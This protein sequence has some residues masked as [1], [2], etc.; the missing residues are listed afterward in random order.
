ML[1]GYLSRETSKLWVWTTL[2]TGEKV[3]HRERRGFPDLSS[4]IQGHFTGFKFYSLLDSGSNP[5]FALVP[6]ST[7]EALRNYLNI[8]SF[9]FL[10][11]K[12]ME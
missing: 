11:S 10:S 6:A 8:L 5:K 2:A 12:K 9:S 4:V 7:C 3:E 1:V